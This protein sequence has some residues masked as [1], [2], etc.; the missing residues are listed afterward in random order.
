MRRYIRPKGQGD[1]TNMYGYYKPIKR[2]YYE[3]MN[4]LKVKVGTFIARGQWA[5][6]HLAYSL[7][8]ENGNEVEGEE[9]AYVQLRGRYGLFMQRI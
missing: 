9:C 2:R 8:D 6:G 4:D 5:D 7:L 3:S 1:I